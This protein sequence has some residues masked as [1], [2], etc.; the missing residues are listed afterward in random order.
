MY[1]LAPHSSGCACLQGLQPLLNALGGDLSALGSSAQINDIFSTAVV[2]TKVMLEQLQN[3]QTLTSMNGNTLTI[4]YT[5]Y[6]GLGYRS[7]CTTSHIE[8]LAGLCK[9][10]AWA[11]PTDQQMTTCQVL[12]TYPATTVCVHVLQCEWR[13]SVLRQQSTHHCCQHPCWKSRHL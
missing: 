3:G 9:R 10:V 13:Q 6:A 7:S 2:T 1:Q 5:T 4:T 11:F 12:L 8:S